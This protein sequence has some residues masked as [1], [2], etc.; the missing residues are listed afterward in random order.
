MR[1]NFAVAIAMAATFDASH[2]MAQTAGNDAADRSAHQ[3]QSSAP[4]TSLAP[5]AATPA[6]MMIFVDPRTHA[7][8]QPDAVDLATFRMQHPQPRASTTPQVRKNPNGGT[9][10]VLDDS[11]GSYM[12]ATRKSDGT[13][14]AQCMPDAE[15]AAATVRV[16]LK[17]GEVLVNGRSGVQ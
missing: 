3:T 12:V 8:R 2:A 16:G 5:A 15:S 1:P 9:V 4:A 14:V 17:S 10:A 11:F 6:G 13:I 7:P